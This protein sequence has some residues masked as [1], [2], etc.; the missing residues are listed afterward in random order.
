[1]GGYEKRLRQMREPWIFGESTVAP[2]SPA[3]RGIDASTHRHQ[4]PA[5]FIRL[6]ST[7]PTD[8]AP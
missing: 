4:L 1:M 5:T 7:E 3:R 8:L 6:T 2:D